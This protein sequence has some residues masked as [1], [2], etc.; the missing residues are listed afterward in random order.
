MPVKQRKHLLGNQMGGDLLADGAKAGQ[1]F[2]GLLRQ[3]RPFGLGY[4]PLFHNDEGTIGNQ[5][6]ALIQTNTTFFECGSGNGVSFP[7]PVTFGFS[8]SN[9]QV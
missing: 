7:P 9:F 4:S 5:L 2:A 3:R 1:G 8:Q 6:M